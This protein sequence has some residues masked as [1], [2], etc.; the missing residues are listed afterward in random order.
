MSP[1]Q[2]RTTLVQHAEQLKAHEATITG[3][4]RRSSPDPFGAFTHDFRLN[5]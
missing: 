4:Q 3:P 2:L 5:P 1:E